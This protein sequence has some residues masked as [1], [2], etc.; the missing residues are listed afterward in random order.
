MA[1]KTAAL[2]AVKP[3][4]CHG[5]R[6][7]KLAS[8]MMLNLCVSMERLV[9]AETSILH[10]PVLAAR[11]VRARRKPE[12]RRWLESPSWGAMLLSTQRICCARVT[13]LVSIAL[14]Q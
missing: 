7:T 1:S 8:S 14:A 11:A 9:P 10:V 4:R 3:K 2:A 13:S 5:V 6:S 12:A